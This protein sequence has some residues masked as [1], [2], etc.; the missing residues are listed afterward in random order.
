MTAIVGE[1]H[2]DR[3]TL[4]NCGHH[5]PLLV[6]PGGHDRRHQ[7]ADAAARPGS[8]PFLTEHAWPGRGML[9][10]TDGLVEARDRTGEVLPLD[11]YAAGS[12]RA[13]SRT[14]WTGWSTGSWPA[15]A[16]G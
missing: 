13:R 5:P 2:G 4:A 9:F 15:L 14:R 3:V 6:R 8:G 7:R 10:Y 1:F 12:A 11:D 16:T